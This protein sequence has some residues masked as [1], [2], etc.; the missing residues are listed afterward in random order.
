MIYDMVALSGQSFALSNA[1]DRLASAIRG[2]SGC[3]GVTLLQDNADEQRFL[4]IE[5]WP[6]REVYQQASRQLPASAFSPI[7]TFLAQ[8]PIR[9]TFTQRP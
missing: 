6:S 2:L 3:A 8:S 1:L 4:F 7:K 5:H 9:R